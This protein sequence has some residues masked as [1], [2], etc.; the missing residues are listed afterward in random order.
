M[1][2]IMVQLM[3]LPPHHLL[4]HYNRDWFDLSGAGLP[5]CLGKKAFNGC[6]SVIDLILAPY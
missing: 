4:L 1:I 3:S 6:L 2:C 5:G